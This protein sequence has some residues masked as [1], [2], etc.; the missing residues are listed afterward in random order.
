M[1]HL[2]KT[3]SMTKTYSELSKLKTFKERYEYLK[4]SGT[5]GEETF[6]H[7]RYLNQIFYKTPEWIEARNKVIIRD[8]G[9]DLGIPGRE[10][11]SNILVHH[12]EPITLEDILNRN[13]K[14]WDLD[15]LIT[16]CMKTHNAIHYGDESLLF[17]ELVERK[18]NDQVPWR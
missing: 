9:N 12:I 17:L 16:T 5:V 7:S 4:L 3:K 1:I 18:P 8:E 10:V 14:C 11:H 2:K 13:P 15:N 6:G